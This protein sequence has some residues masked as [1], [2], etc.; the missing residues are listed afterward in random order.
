MLVGAIIG[1]LYGF[2]GYVYLIEEQT[3]DRIFMRY[4][5]EPYPIGFK[6]RCDRV[7]KSYYS[8]GMVKQYHTDLVVLDPEK[9]TPYKKTIIVN[10]P[11]SHNGLTFYQGDTFPAKIYVVKVTNPRSNMQK[12]FNINPGQQIDCP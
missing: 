5:D 4:T 11:L 6:L 1:G 3:T 10:D 2:Q 7:A 12:T 8:N 9:N